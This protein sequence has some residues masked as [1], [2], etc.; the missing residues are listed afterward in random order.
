MGNL[1][2]G[3]R[4]TLDSLPFNGEKTKLFA[5]FL[6][7][8]LLKS[9]FPTLNLEEVWTFI[10]ANVE[11]PTLGIVLSLLHKWLKSREATR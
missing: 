10:T 11:V 3:L 8:V 4:L 6:A 2:N 9:A 7:Y 5:F 1:L